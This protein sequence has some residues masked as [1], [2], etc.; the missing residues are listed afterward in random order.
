MDE[1]Q[2][3]EDL[4]GVETSQDAS[5]DNAVS[6]ND[7]DIPSCDD[8]LPL[9]GTQLTSLIADVHALV[10]RRNVI[11]PRTLFV[12]EPIVKVAEPPPSGP[13]VETRQAKRAVLVLLRRLLPHPPVRTCSPP[14][15][16][17]WRRGWTR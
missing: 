1:E 15:F 13:A 12:E 8:E 14:G 2:E 3:E 16:T 4:A 10:W 6:D 11:A 17:I 5:G 7:E 9:S